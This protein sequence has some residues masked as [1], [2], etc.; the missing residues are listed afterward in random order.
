MDF[1][2]GLE[3]RLTSFLLIL[4]MLLY[5]VLVASN[6]TKTLSAKRARRKK[7][8]LVEFLDI[9]AFVGTVALIALCGTVRSRLSS[10][11]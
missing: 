11:R 8:S 10:A 7:N 9:W 1:K 6:A 4:R 2:P 5:D 3:L